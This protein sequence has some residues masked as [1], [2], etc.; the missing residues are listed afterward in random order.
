MDV[1]EN[2]Q[3]EPNGVEHIFPEPSTLSTSPKP[4]P[5]RYSA[6]PEALLQHAETVEEI[7]DISSASSSS[8]EGEISDDSSRKISVE[9]QVLAEFDQS[10]G[11]YEPNLMGTNLPTQNLKPRNSKSVEANQMML[12]GTVQ[13]GEP[14]LL[15][16]REERHTPEDIQMEEPHGILDAQEQTKVHDDVVLD[17]ASDSDDYEPPEASSLVD[18]QAV[19]VD[20][21]PFSPKSFSPPVQNIP[22]QQ[23]ALVPVSPGGTPH[24]KDD[25][26]LTERDPSVVKEVCHSMCEMLPTANLDSGCAKTPQFETWPFHP[27]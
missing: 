19:S 9:R 27:L 22:E 4:Q 7:M 11:K 3:M 8:D 6:A 13:S 2:P 17:I 21:E 23:Y 14:A 10:Q 5:P 1:A 24:Q 20:S 25:G 12:G 18:N 16:N 26:K 15:A